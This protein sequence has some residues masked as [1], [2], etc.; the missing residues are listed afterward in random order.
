[1]I[2]TAEAHAK[3][4]ELPQLPRVLL[5][6]DEIAI[7]DALRRQLRRQFDVTTATSGAAA[8]EILADSDP[9]AVVLSDMRMPG[10]DG[11]TFLA[12][13]REQYP[14][15]VRMLLTGQ[16]D[17]Q[18]AIA[19]INDGQIYRFLSKPCPTDALTTALNDGSALHQQI[20]A[21]KDVLERTL[22]SA[23]QS[24][25]DVLALANPD[26]FSRAVRV[27]HLVGHLCELMEIPVDWELQVSGLLGQL[28]AVTV[29]LPVLEKIDSGLLLNVDEQKMVDAIPGMS[30][31]LIA[32][33]P[34][35][36]RLAA[37]LGQQRLRY[38]GRGTPVGEPVGEAI[39][40]AARLL[41]FV[42]DV[43]TMRTQRLPAAAALDRMRKDAGA[44]DPRLLGV[45][46]RTHEQS[47]DAPECVPITVDFDQLEPGMVLVEDVLSGSGVVL[48]GRGSTVT[49]ALLQRLRNHV[50][51]SGVSG[52]IVVSSRL[53]ARTKGADS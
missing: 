51:H 47:S 52:P 42:V 12:R 40:F 44:Y 37:A 18:S 36:E 28:G 22:R 4:Y 50:R 17:M 16:A 21:E 38:D 24:L 13:V 6:D 20:T 5:V 27:S 15:T 19:A 34:R 33:I 49:E 26:A 43:D 11:A 1:M 46:E 2:Q 14:D 39:P 8:L 25:V 23:V 31:N 10:M 7:V 30:Q 9:F 29:P 3:T 41:R 53:A 48:L 45:W 35:L 32:S